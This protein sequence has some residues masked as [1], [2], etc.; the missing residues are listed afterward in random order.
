MLSRLF[1]DFPISIHGYMLAPSSLCFPSSL[2]GLSPAY[3]LNRPQWPCW[4]SLYLP[5]SDIHCSHQQI[6]WLS[7]EV[8]S[9][10]KG[11][12]DHTPA[13]GNLYWAF[14]CPTT[15]FKCCNILA[16]LWDR[17]HH[18]HLVNM[19]AQVRWVPHLLTSKEG[20]KGPLAFPELSVYLCMTSPAHQ[21]EWCEVQIYRELLPVSHVEGELSHLIAAQSA[22]VC[23]R[24]AFSP[25]LSTCACSRAAFSSGIHQHSAQNCLFVSVLL[26]WAPGTCYGLLNIYRTSDY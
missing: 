16:S 11:S 12:G 17:Y 19:K 21:G 9:P 8:T 7:W 23:S 2:Q 6:F 3:P 18:F 15:H 22:C 25:A 10:V 26:G 5:A 20:T 14:L 1:W 24:A 4:C 13:K